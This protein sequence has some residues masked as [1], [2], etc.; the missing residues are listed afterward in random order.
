MGDDAVDLVGDGQLTGCLPFIGP[1]EDR[2]NVVVTLVGNDALGVVVQLLLC[3]TDILFDV[4]QEWLGDVDLF[5]GLFVPLKDFDGIP[6][7]LIGG[8]IV[9]DC[10]L[11]VGQGVFHWAG[12]VVGGDRLGG[13]GS[14]DGC[15]SGFHDASGFEGRYLHH[16][17]A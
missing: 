10:F 11:D 3:G 9:K 7:L 14:V 16:L 2:A 17:A 5:Q 12:K 15:L 13:A 4:V 8:H 6:A 1:L